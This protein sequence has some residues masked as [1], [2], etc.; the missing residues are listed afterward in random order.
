MSKRSTSSQGSRLACVLVVAVLTTVTS[1][2][3]G[4]ALSSYGQWRPGRA[5]PLDP[6]L[7]V[8][9]YKVRYQRW[10]WLPGPDE[11]R[12]PISKEEWRHLSEY[13][14]K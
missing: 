1:L 9:Y 5:V 10:Q 11:V 7:Q 6:A 2:L 14:S 4:L 3:V 13:N 12:Q 8:S